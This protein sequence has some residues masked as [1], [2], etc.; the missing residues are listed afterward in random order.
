MAVDFVRGKLIA[1]VLKYKRLCIFSIT[2]EEV[3]AGES[4][5]SFAHEELPSQMLTD[6]T[7][8]TPW[9]AAIDKDSLVWVHVW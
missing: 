8:L 5:G 6:F 7:D 1:I 3:A 9:A 4:D 2:T